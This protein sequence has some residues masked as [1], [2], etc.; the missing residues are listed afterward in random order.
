M[1]ILD[2]AAKL[3]TRKLPKVI[4]PKTHSIIDYAVA[5]SFFYSWRSSVETQ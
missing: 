3:A 1:P 2:Q 5:G 4:S